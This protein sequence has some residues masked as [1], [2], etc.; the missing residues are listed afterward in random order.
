MAKQRQEESVLQGLLHAT[1]AENGECLPDDEHAKQNF[2]VLWNLA[3]EKHP[4]EE[5]V[6][7]PARISIQLAVGGWAITV[8][9]NTLRKKATVFSATLQGCFEAWEKAV[10]DRAVPWM[11][12]GKGDLKVPT[13]KKQN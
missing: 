2:P 3:T 9:S 13:R 11:E 8:S 6:V 4:T 7:Q 1:L 10:R 12:W 5:H